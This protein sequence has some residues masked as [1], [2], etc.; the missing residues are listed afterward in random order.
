MKII[1]IGYGYWGKKIYQTLTKLISKKNILIIDKNIKNKDITNKN[2]DEVLKNKE[3]THCL[4]AT[5]EETHFRITKKCLLAKKN[6]FVEKPLCLQ[7][8][9]AQELIKL[10]KK[11]KKI[12]SVDYTFLYD[13]YIKTIKKIINN[14]KLGKIK[15]IE[16][17]RHSININKPYVSVF[18]DL[19]THDIYL[20]EYLL[21]TKIK[22]IKVNKLKNKKKQIEQG[23]VTYYSENQSMKSNYS[24]IQLE[25]QR[26]MTFIGTKASLIW[27]KENK[28]LLLLKNGQLQEKINVKL[29]IPPLE[30]SI[31]TFLS[32]E[33]SNTQNIKNYIRHV[34][35]LEKINLS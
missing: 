14:K 10:A 5:P 31:S 15:L 29:N 12:L 34:S 17:I 19:A 13:P 30:Q 21:D 1:L 2:L 20:Y 9:Q 26:K 22:K 3:I 35:W 4:I 18:D 25:A 24:W 8:K 27:N 33:T 16:S 28:S 23:E 32:Q 6:V 11:N 7:K